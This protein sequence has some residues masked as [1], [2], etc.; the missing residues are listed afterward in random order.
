MNLLP[1]AMARSVQPDRAAESSAIL[2]IERIIVKYDLYT[3]NILLCIGLQKSISLNEFASLNLTS[4]RRYCSILPPEGGRPSEESEHSVSVGWTREG[5]SYS[6][7][8]IHGLNFAPE[9]QGRVGHRS[10]PSPETS[11][12]SDF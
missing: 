12:L 10:E 8:S 1:V 7:Q 6:C 2:H 11:H 9:N 5:T 4:N 3:R